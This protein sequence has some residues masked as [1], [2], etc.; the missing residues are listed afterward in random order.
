MILTKKQRK[1][2]TIIIGIA[3]VALVISSFLPF[4]LALR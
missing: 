2:V 4:I 3:T 1:I